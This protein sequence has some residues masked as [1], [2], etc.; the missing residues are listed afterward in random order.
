[1]LVFINMKN[2]QAHVGSKRTYRMGA[3]AEAAEETRVRILD[4]VIGLHMERYHDQI[5]LDE[6]AGRAGVTVQTVLR[7]FG[8]KEGLIDA[9][10][11]VVRGRVTSQRSEAPVGDVA[12]A[13]ENLVDH[14]EEWGESVL[15][16]LAQEDRV[17]AFRKATDAGRALHREWVER[18]FAPFLAGR[19]GGAR[20]RLLAELVAVCDVYFWKV[21]RKDLGL[22]RG[23]T[24]LAL[25]ETIVAL[26]GEG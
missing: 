4:A 5:S 13:V 19:A 9:A 1:M 20:G 26:K 22:D 8:S 18:T 14:Y 10:S 3:R 12:G 25:R 21:L 11:E 15:R 17:P 16:L 23:Q 7:R 2:D 24:A 6:V